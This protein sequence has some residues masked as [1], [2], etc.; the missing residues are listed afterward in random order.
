MLIISITVFQKMLHKAK[1]LSP[2]R[3]IEGEKTTANMTH[4]ATIKSLLPIRYTNMDSYPIIMIRASK[5]K[6]R[7]CLPLKLHGLPIKLMNLPLKLN[8]LPDKPQSPLLMSNGLLQAKVWVTSIAKEQFSSMFT[9]FH[10]EEKKNKNQLTTNFCSSTRINS[11]FRIY[12]RTNSG[13]DRGR[14]NTTCRT[15]SAPAVAICSTRVSSL[16]LIESS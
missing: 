5:Y 10:K 2:L 9:P 16:I 1:G 14:E 12:T 6:T 15:A 8:D 7:I 13:K 3:R 4:L 11:T